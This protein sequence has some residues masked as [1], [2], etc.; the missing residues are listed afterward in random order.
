MLESD[1]IALHYEVVA[2]TAHKIDKVANELATLYKASYFN[3]KWATLQKKKLI[4]YFNELHIL[5]NSY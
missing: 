4:Q 1:R 2:N 5:M 3:E